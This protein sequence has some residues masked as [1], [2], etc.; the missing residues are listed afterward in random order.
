MS[1]VAAPVAMSG[2]LREGLA[3]YPIHVVLASIGLLA[4]LVA[5]IDPSLISRYNP[6]AI[7]PSHALVGPSPAH[8]FGTDEDGRDVYARIVY[9]ARPALLIGLVGAGIGTLFGTTLGVLSGLGGR[10]PDLAVG[11]LTELMLA[12]PALVLALLLS[13]FLG[14]SVTVEAIA[15]GVGNVPTFVRVT[16]AQTLVV[17]RSQYVQAAGALGHSRRRV[18]L[19]TIVPNVLRPLLA[20][21][22]LAIGQSIV[23]G[24]A[25]SFLGLGA[26]PPEA[27]WGL[28]LSDS[29]SYLGVGWWL[30]AFPGLA[31]VAT[32]LS[33]STVGMAV[34]RRI[35]GRGSF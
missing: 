30:A 35:D 33:I 31:I 21:T 16:R 15:V 24:S 14:A 1:Y 10:W 4:L 29:Q 22:T 7:D 12:F 26:R 23:W 9:G 2:R 11:R 8:W 3:R 6:I 27:E 13:A 34:Q 20:F 25:L 17:S 18:V 19:M 32:S 5:L 28:M